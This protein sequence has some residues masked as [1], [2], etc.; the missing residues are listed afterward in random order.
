MTIGEWAAGEKPVRI[1]T[2]VLALNHAIGPKSAKVTETQVLRDAFFKK[3]Y[4]IKCT[5]SRKNGDGEYEIL[6]QGIGSFYSS[7][8]VHIYIYV[9]PTFPL[10]HNTH[11]HTHTHTH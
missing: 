7:S 9:F 6:S 10:F 4:K 11:T 1:L 8:S 2:Y 3:V 5:M